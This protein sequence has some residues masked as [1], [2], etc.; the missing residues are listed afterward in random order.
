MAIGI[1]QAASLADSAF[2][3]K[4]RKDFG[5]CGLPVELPFPLDTLKQAMTLDKKAERGI[6]HFVV[7][8]SVGDVRIEDMTVEEALSRLG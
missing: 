2:A 1:I 3:E 6:V 8:R 4:L 5:A 7:P